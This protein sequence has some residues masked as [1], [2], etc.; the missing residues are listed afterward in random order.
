M[1]TILVPIN[2]F[3]LASLDLD[4]LATK[5]GTDYRVNNQDDKVTRFISTVI[6]P[7]IIQGVS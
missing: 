6:G 2:M 1:K 3:L 4:S 5:R 7:Q